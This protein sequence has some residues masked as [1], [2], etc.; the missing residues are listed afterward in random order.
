MFRANVQPRKD[1]SLDRKL[2]RYLSWAAF[3]DKFARLLL[4]VRQSSRGNE[5]LERER[6]KR[7][8]GRKKDEFEPGSESESPISNV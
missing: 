4:N 2:T 1:M 3:A 6:S 8:S 7:V 5:T